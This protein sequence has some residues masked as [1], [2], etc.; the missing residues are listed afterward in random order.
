MGVFSDVSMIRRAILHMNRSPGRKR[1]SMPNLNIE[2]GT[3]WQ[4]C[5]TRAENGESACRSSL[6][7]SAQQRRDD[8]CRHGD[9]T[10]GDAE[11]KA[12]LESTAEAFLDHRDD[13]EGNRRNH[14][15][16]E[17]PRHSETDG[18]EDLREHFGLS[19]SLPSQ[20]LIIQHR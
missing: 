20:K 13:K 8:D 18:S 9:E 10:G 17:G 4:A 19:V 7:P 16:C 12:R 5:L 11:R 1:S 2:A 6:P 15:N 3:Q 14:C